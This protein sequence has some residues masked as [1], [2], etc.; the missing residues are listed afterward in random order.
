MIAA[1]AAWPSA[2]LA[3][4]A[5]DGAASHTLL[6]SVPP[7]LQQFL[8]DYGTLIAYGLIGLVAAVTLGWLTVQFHD[9]FNRQFEKLPAGLRRAARTGRWTTA[10]R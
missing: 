6:G 8:A 4:V 1:A 9:T 3:N 5:H 7:R 2:A 10:L